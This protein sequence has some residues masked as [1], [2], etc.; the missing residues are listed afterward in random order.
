MVMD[1]MESTLLMP[2]VKGGGG[3]RDMEHLRKTKELG[4]SEKGRIE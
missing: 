1:N 4:E 2:G 3:G